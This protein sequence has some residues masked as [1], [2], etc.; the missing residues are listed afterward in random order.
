MTP[1][2][3]LYGRGAGRPLSPRRQALLDAWG[4]RAALPDGRINAASLGSRADRPLALEI[5]FG[6]GEHL[7]GRAAADPA[8]L[9]LGVEPFLDGVGKLVAALDDAPLDNVRFHRGDARDVLDRIEDAA[10]HA[11]YLMFPDPWPKS[12]HA[13]RRFVQTD[14][15]RAFHRTLKPGGLLVIASDVRAYLDWSLFHVRAHGGFSWTAR[16]ADDWR[17]APAGHVPTRYET[18]N[19]G[20]CTPAFL[21]FQRRAD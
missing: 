12:R 8:T 17:S 1:A 9:Y 5:G 14:T 4:A 7:H 21:V 3:R 2:R 18:K 13:R 6:G 16:T 20:D 19:I 15:V 10:L 11:I